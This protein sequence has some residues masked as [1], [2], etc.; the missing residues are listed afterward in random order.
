MPSDTPPP[1][2]KGHFQTAGQDV[3][4][5]GDDHTLAVQLANQLINIANKRLEEGIRPD[6][7]ASGMRHAAANFSAFVAGHMAP[8]MIEEGVLVEEFAQMVDYY[9]KVHG[10][11]EASTGLHQLVEQAK[12]D[13]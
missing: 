4:G 10:V 9:A 2:Q 6:I 8:E 11:G 12:S 3:N 7:I 1:P 5:Q 13:F